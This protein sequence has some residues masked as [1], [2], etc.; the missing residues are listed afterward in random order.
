MSLEQLNSEKDI[1]Q[2]MLA[3]INDILGKTQ[4]A[5]LISK[6]TKYKSDYESKLLQIEAAVSKTKTANKL[7]PEPIDFEKEVEE[8]ARLEKE[9]K[10]REEAKPEVTSETVVAKESKLEPALK[11]N[12]GIDI[13]EFL[14][15]MVKEIPSK[16]IAKLLGVK[17]SNSKTYKNM[18]RMPKVKFIPRIKT[19]MTDEE[20]FN[21]YV[22]DKFEQWKQRKGNGLKGGGPSD[23]YYSQGN[24][25]A[26]NQYNP[27]NQPMSYNQIPYNQPMPYNQM[28]YNQPMPYNQMPYNPQQPYGQMPY[29]PQAQLLNLN[30]YTHSN[31]AL[32]LTSKL[33]Y[34]VSVELELYPG[35]T[36]NTVQMAA[37]KCGSTF[38]RIREA[39]SEIMGYQ[40]RPGTMDESYAYQNL[41]QNQ[42]QNQNQNQRSNEQRREEMEQRQ[43][44]GGSKSLKNKKSNKRS[45]SCKIYKKNKN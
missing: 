7:K 1:D 15:E 34:Y 26:E 23:E 17:A 3:K 37:V 29:N 16:Q 21:K 20:D 36:A 4:N 43:I 2:A 25:N 10:E 45:V 22:I 24:V 38:E 35:K 33:A 11:L 14:R 27:Y 6:Y 5:E 42:N 30:Q 13:D 44:K 41:P 9:E 39:W 28:P 32:E 31:R 12:N 8:A 40:Y 19:K 18:L